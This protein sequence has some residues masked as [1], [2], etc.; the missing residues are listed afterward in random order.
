MSKKHQAQQRPRPPPTPDSRPNVTASRKDPDPC[1]RT[2]TQKTAPRANTG[3]PSCFEHPPPHQL[4]PPQRRRRHPLTRE[5]GRSRSPH[6]KSPRDHIRGA[7]RPGAHLPGTP[8]R[9]A[10]WSR[11]SARPC[12]V[13]AEEKRQTGGGGERKGKAGA[14]VSP[15]PSPVPY[16]TAGPAPPDHPAAEPVGGRRGEARRAGAHLSHGSGGAAPTAGE[17]AG[18]RGSQKWGWRRRV[19]PAGG[20]GARAKGGGA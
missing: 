12:P 18:E 1:P 3:R 5:S 7:H 8:P 20:R 11:L 16:R 2:A 19:T 14:R 17:R 4:R 13:A 9:N 10:A 15:G 6:G